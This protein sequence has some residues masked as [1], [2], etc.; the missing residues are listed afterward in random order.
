MNEEKPQE[1]WG[2]GGE[3]PYPLTDKSWTHHFEQ[4]TAN[5]LVKL[6]NSVYFN[7]ELYGLHVYSERQNDNARGEVSARQDN[8]EQSGDNPFPVRPEHPEDNAVP[9]CSDDAQN[10]QKDHDGQSFRRMGQIWMGNAVVVNWRPPHV[11]IQGWIIDWRRYGWCG[12][13]HCRF[14]KFG[15]N[16]TCKERAVV[17]MRYFWNADLFQLLLW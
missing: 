17:V 9:E 2:K 5:H 15:R 1:K 6:A 7:I 10:R 8:D 16:W 12:V 4:K 13:V 11:R 14:Q 3:G